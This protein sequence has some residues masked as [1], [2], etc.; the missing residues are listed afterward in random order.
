[1]GARAPRSR[2]RVE[3]SIYIIHRYQISRMLRLKLFAVKHVVCPVAFGACQ[4]HYF[5]FIQL[6]CD[7]WLNIIVRG[8]DARPGDLFDDGPSWAGGRWSGPVAAAVVDV[9]IRI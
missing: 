8:L 1:M 4:I 3:L 7:P 9:A 2:P 6:Q 5:D